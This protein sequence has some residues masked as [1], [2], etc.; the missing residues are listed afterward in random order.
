MGVISWSSS[1]SLAVTSFWFDPA[2]GR[3]RLTREL[4]DRFC[5]GVA[6]TFAR[7]GRDNVRGGDEDDGCRRGG[8]ELHVSRGSVG[9]EL[10]A[11]PLEP[12][13]VCMEEEHEE[14]DGGNRGGGGDD[15][16]EKR[17]DDEEDDDRAEVLGAVRPLVARVFGQFRDVLETVL[18]RHPGAPVSAAV[19]EQV[20]LSGLARQVLGVIAPTLVVELN[21][22]RANGRL[23]GD[24]VDAR[25]HNFLDDLDDESRAPTMLGQYPVLAELL[26]AVLTARADARLECLRHLCEDWPAIGQ[27][28]PALA[29]AR[30]AGVAAAVGDPSVVGGRRWCSSSSLRG[31]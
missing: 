23:R 4:F 31:C 12:P 14:E 25:F 9:A 7:V 13:E 27:C 1:A 24:T 19:G 8:E 18:R 26:R 2:I 16:D 28:W 6:V 20:F 21:A 30:L 29:E 17:E 10:R 11:V 15:D 5:S 3:R 22:A